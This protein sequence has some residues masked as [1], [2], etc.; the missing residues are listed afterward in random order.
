MATGTTPMTSPDNFEKLAGALSATVAARAAAPL[1]AQPWDRTADAMTYLSLIQRQ[2]PDL[3]ADVL[4]DMVAPAVP[5]ILQDAREI[6][7]AML[8]DPTEKHLEA[9]HALVREELLA[10]TVVFD[11]GSPTHDAACNEL[12]DLRAASTV[13]RPAWDAARRPPARRRGRPPALAR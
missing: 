8:D 1:G 3:P 5:R 12:N 2:N 11:D 7:H 10:L 9:K 13:A 4:A 6:R